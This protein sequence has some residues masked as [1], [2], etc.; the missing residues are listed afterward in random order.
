FLSGTV[1]ATSTFSNHHC[2]RQ[3]PSAAERLTRCRLRHGASLCFTGWSKTPE[4]QGSACLRFPKWWDCRHEP[5][6]LAC[7]EF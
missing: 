1:T 4:L 5:S 7:C 6:C 2:S 3:H